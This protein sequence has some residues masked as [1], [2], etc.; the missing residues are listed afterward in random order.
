MRCKWSAL[1]WMLFVIAAA[2]RAERL[3][4]K[5]YGL[6]DGLP[7]TFVDHIVSDSRGLLWFSTRDGLARF[8]GSRFVSYG[9]ED[10]L[11][12]PQVTFLLES[13][14]GMYW[15][16]TNGGG[17]CRMD[18]GAVAVAEQSKTSARARTRF[19]CVS[20]GAS[21]ADHVN[22]LHEDP[23]GRIW[24]GT[25][26]GLFRFDVAPDA[27]HQPLRID[28]GAAWRDGRR[29]GVSALISGD[30]GEMWIGTGRALVRLDDEHGAVRYPVPA[31]AVEAPVRDLARAA[32]GEIWVAYPRGLLRI[33]GAAQTCTLPRRGARPGESYEWIDLTDAEIG[34]S[35]LVLSATGRV[36]I[37]TDRG[38]LEFDGRG[39]RQYGAAHG[40]PNRLISE[41][42]ED[43]D[44]NLW[45][46]SLSGVT[47]LKPDG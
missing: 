6:A 11:A 4:V 21:D 9:V 35:A 5:T 19:E 23:F 3:P 2:A 14:R 16:A 40:L 27:S 45:I 1:P 26:G 36:W 33:C 42:A 7:S 13:R 30:N 34:E 22:V 32:S 10:G 18:P 43:R 44:Q 46:A 17:V 47:K 39:F 37:G 12:V 41:L 38:L 15:V 29:V 25:D 24:A 8:D 28:I 20:L 31:S